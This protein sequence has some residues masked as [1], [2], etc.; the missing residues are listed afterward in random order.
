MSHGGLFLSH[1]A[2]ARDSSDFFPAASGWTHIPPGVSRGRLC[3]IDRLVNGLNVAP[4]QPLIAQSSKRCVE[5][6]E[7]ILVAALHLLLDP[8]HNGLGVPTTDSGYSM[9]HGSNESP[10]P[11]GTLVR[12]RRVGHQRIGVL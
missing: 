3:R 4:A 2:L 8:M 11:M 5:H 9:T 1:E 7:Q 10:I 6:V 12:T